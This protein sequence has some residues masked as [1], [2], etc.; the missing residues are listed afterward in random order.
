MP[1]VAG[2]GR[3]SVSGLA[4]RGRGHTPGGFRDGRRRFPDV[5]GETFEVPGGGGGEELVS[6]ESSSRSPASAKSSGKRDHD[7]NSRASRLFQRYR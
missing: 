6:G 2:A 5:L 1:P 3:H 4:V 7:L